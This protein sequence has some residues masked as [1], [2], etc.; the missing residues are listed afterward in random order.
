LPI[1]LSSLLPSDPS[2][3][4]LA[5]AEA[6]L[7]VL[8]AVFGPDN[9][10]RTPAPAGETVF[11]EEFKY[12]SLVERLPAV[13]FMASLDGG[14]GDAYVSPQIEASLGF[15]QEEWLQDPI[16]WY[17]HIH[18]DDKERWSI[19]A[20]EMFISGRP[21]KSVYRVM[22]RSGKVVWF[23]CEASMLR[24]DDGR[25]WAIH[26]VAFDVTTLKQSEQSLYEKNGQLE[27][28]KDIATEANQA[29]TVHE[30][31]QFAV[32]R[33]CAFT[34]WPLGHACTPAGT[35]I[36][37]ETHD[38]RFDVFRAS[39]ESGGFS[40]SGD[41]PARAVEGARPL[42]V[43]DLAH[44][45]HFARRA[46]AQQAGIQSAFAFPVLSGS[47]VIGVL[48]FF[49]LEPRD[50]DDALLE[51]MT[52]VG[53]QM[54]QVVDRIERLAAENQLQQTLRLQNDQLEE[55]V[56][57]RTEQLQL[58]TDRANAMAAEAAAANAAKSEFLANM[59]HEI[60]TPLNGVIGMTDLALD[61]EMSTDQRECLETIKLSAHSLLAVVNEI[62]D[63]SKIESGKLDLEMIAFNLRD[64][65]EE[66][67]K[68]FAVS[69]G[70]KGLELLCDIAEDV[71]VVVTGDPGR[72]RQIILNLVSNAVKF[73]PEG[74]ILLHVALE[75]EKSAD[76][77][78]PVVRFT[79]ADTGIGIP[80]E[81]Q[82]SIFAPFTQ[83]DTSTTRKYGGT[84]LGLTIASSLAAMMGGRMWLQST[85]G[86][87][88]RISFTARFS[89]LKQ[90]I[91]A[92]ET[93]GWGQQLRDVKVLVVD[94]NQTNRRILQG[95]LQLWGAQIGLTDGA[96]KALHELTLASESGR[97][98]Q[99]VV[100][101]MHMPGMDGFDLVKNMRSR[102]AIANTLVVMLTSGGRRGDMER[103]RELG[104]SAYA[105]KPIRRRE[106][107]SAIITALGQLPGADIT[108]VDRAKPAAKPLRIL[109]AEDSRINQTIATRVLEKLGHTVKIANNGKEAISMLPLNAFDLV[110]MDI[111]M[112]EM[113]GLTATAHIRDRET[114]TRNHLPIIAMTAHAM[115]GDRERCLAAGMDGYVTKPIDVLDLENTITAV[116]GRWEM[117]GSKPA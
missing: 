109:L 24:R 30:A 84:G 77:D 17:Q 96:E 85:V 72:L 88:T 83:A 82:D 94:D 6:T 67:L 28:L 112:P 61:T 106:L 39:S 98:Y 114:G 29:T 87:G 11:S 56:R 31:L 15:S 74:E 45:P 46:E 78:T 55:A 113:D 80:A 16:R 65:M 44:D 92:E 100:T 79:V 73:T 20:A 26:G 37:S 116:T 57:Q 21:L 95:T 99:V 71:P 58:A 75:K 115:K 63:F 18:P 34:A 33:V 60:R 9:P 110:L 8:A 107:F 42:W 40:A 104:I 70:E 25:P 59:S 43:K 86:E 14:S 64:C 13:I 81:K 48:E 90:G 27:L 101:D 2:A 68:T 91:E 108:V 102:A 50:R 76:Q 49:A 62:L 5:D 54:G 66:A 10:S 89:T 32:N 103:C 36:W 41:L 69:A 117:A 1:D 22:S 38:H 52:L 93:S 53:N 23:Q 3:L 7:A 47:E 19:E 111:Q 51:V 12:R 105:H 97:P 4:D 35:H